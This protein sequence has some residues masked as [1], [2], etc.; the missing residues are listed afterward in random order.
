MKSKILSRNEAEKKASELK[1]K[2]LIIGLTNGVFDLIHSGHIE[3]LEKA[4]KKCDKLFVSVN[5]DSSVKKFKSK[6]R[7]F[8][9]LKERQKVLAGLEC[10]DFILNHPQ[11]GM[12]E[13]IELIK[14]N[15]YFKGGDYKISD[16]KS[17]KTIEENSGKIIIIP[18]SKGKSTTNT[19][20]KILKT[21]AIKKTELKKQKKKA[22]FLDRDGTINK[23]VDFL[24]E[25]KK[26]EFLPNALKGIKRMQ[27]KGFE[28]IIIT[29]Q[30]G[31]GLGYF[32]E[33][34]FFKVNRKML[35]EM[36]ENKIKIMGI[37]FCPH[38]E[39][40]NC[41]CRKPKP[42]LIIKAAKEHNIDLSKSYMIGDTKE[43]IDSGKK[44]EIKTIILGKEKIN[45]DFKAKDLL[46]A[47]KKIK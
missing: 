28:I 46:E 35:S 14:P 32:P 44:A 24:H 33:E 34:D 27:E 2:G 22:V 25:P 9:S 1:K 37:Y 21:Y 38:T 6:N 5:T 43:D 31:I 11:T 10:I 12:K 16:L 3:Y 40:D 15:V 26:F 13:T 39:A 18:F 7:P 20:N 8:N 4:R 42:G 23:H 45:A 29:N 47:A 19:V 41:E 30:Q 36:N 17:R